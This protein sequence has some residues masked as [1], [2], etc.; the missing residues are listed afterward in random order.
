MHKNLDESSLA[1]RTT[2]QWPKLGKKLGMSQG[3]REGGS[4]RALEI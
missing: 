4:D 1:K 2:A 3:D